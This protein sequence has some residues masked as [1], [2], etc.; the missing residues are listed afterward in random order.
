LCWPHCCSCHGGSLLIRIK[1]GIDLCGLVRTVHDYDLAPCPRAPRLMQLPVGPPAVALQQAGLIAVRHGARGTQLQRAVWQP[2]SGGG[3]DDPALP[4]ERISL[5]QTS[6]RRPA[7][8]P[9][10]LQQ[11][12]ASGRCRTAADAC[13]MLFPDCA[14]EQLEA[15]HCM[16]QGRCGPCVVSVQLGQKCCTLNL[17]AEPSCSV[18]LH[19]GTDSPLAPVV[20]Q[21]DWQPPFC[22]GAPTHV[23][24]ETCSTSTA[25]CAGAWDEEALLEGTEAG[26]ALQAGPPPEAALPSA[27]AAALGNGTAWLDLDSAMTMR[28]LTNRA[29]DDLLQC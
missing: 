24:H 10:Q 8:D 11:R 5:R 26:D 6:R 17:L 12:A 1:Q 13:W 21:S 29:L 20:S 15:A 16:T 3:G 9:A 2:C 4:G 27:R 7:A 22:V 18:G 28:H 14:P 25:T 19:S 23:E